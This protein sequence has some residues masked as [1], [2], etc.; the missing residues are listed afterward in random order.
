MRREE[1]IVPNVSDVFILIS[2]LVNK[3]GRFFAVMTAIFLIIA[4]TLSPSIAFAA[5]SDGIFNF[6]GIIDQLKW[7]V[8]FILLPVAIVFVAWKVLYL[9]LVVGL[10]GVDPLGYAGG[11]LGYDMLVPKIKNALMGTLYGLCWVGGVF[12]IFQLVLIVASAITG[13]FAE[14]FG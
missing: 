5:E 10:F 8:T 9:A 14:S 7:V 3:R 1:N 13:V 12:I 4:I 11:N 6:S 2:E